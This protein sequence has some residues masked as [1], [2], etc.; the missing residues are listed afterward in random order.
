MQNFITTT[1]LFFLLT[2]VAFG[3]AEL[4]CD[5]Q[6]YVDDVFTDFTVTTV[7]YGSNTTFLGLNQDLKMDI[8][9]P[10]GDTHAQ[11]PVVILAFGGSFIFGARESM[12]EFCELF[13]KKGYVAATIDYRTGFVGT[14]EEAITGAVVRAVSDMKA[15]IRYFRQDAATTNTFKIHPDYILAGGYSAGAITATHAA[16]LD[17]NDDISTVVEDVIN[18]NGGIDGNT[19]DATNQSYSSDIFAVYSLSGALQKKEYLGANETEPLVSFHGKDDS[20]VPYNSG[21]A[22]GTYAVDGTAVIHQQADDIG[23][24]NYFMGVDGGGHT[25]IHF[26]SFYETERNEFQLNSSVFLHNLMCPDN[27]ISVSTDDIAKIQQSLDIYP[28]PSEDVMNF[29][30][31]RLESDYSIR[32][33]DQVGRL[34][35]SFDNQNDQVF[36]LNKNEIGEGM[37][38]VNVLFEDLEVASLTR[39]V[40]FK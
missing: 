5:G 40:V 32:V 9:E 38:F 26:D 8:Y 12:A 25:D 31:G 23:L 17:M 16:Y 28:N 30:F 4:A 36:Y 34:V 29:D 22:L 13:V 7:T 24:S 6:R 15:A 10:V 21:N 39:R 3:Q 19:G 1:I 37:F 11:R 2:Q 33:Y 14:S 27:F 35:A 18:D 20:T